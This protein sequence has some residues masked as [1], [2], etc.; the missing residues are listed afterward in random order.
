MDGAAECPA[1][2][3]NEGGGWTKRG[4]GHEYGNGHTMSVHYNWITRPVGLEHEFDAEKRQK[5]GST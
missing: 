3:M 1:D 2:I 5:Y 4:V